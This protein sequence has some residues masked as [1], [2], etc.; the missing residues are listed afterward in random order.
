M[1]K[2]FRSPN[3][4]ELPDD[5]LGE[6]LL[7]LYDRESKDLELFNSI[8]SEVIKLSGSKVNYYKVFIN[9]NFDKVYL[10]ERNKI[11]AKDP[12][13]VWAS[14]DPKPI[15][16]ELSEFGLELSNDQVFVFNKSYIDRILGRPPQAGDVIEAT[17]QNVR[18][19]IYEVQEDSFEVYGVYHYNCFGKVLRDSIDVVDGPVV[20][21]FDQPIVETTLNS[22]LES[23]DPYNDIRPSI[24]STTTNNQEQGAGALESNV[25]LVGETKNIIIAIGQ[26]N[27]DGVS[28]PIQ[29]PTIPSEFLGQQSWYQIW[30]PDDLSSSSGS[31]DSMFPMNAEDPP[32]GGLNATRYSI[33]DTA[34]RFNIYSVRHYDFLL[35]FVKLVYDAQPGTEPVY[36]FKNTKGG[37]AMVSGLEIASVLSWTDSSSPVYN[38][39]GSGLYTTLITDVALGVSSLRARYPNDDI[40]IRAVL[41][42][43]GEFECLDIAGLAGYSGGD[44]PANAWGEAFSGTLYPNLQ[45][46]LTIIETSYGLTRSNDV[47]IPFIIGRTHREIENA[48]YA[49]VDIVRQAQEA[50][51]ADENLNVHLVNLDGLTFKPGENTNL[52]FDAASLTTIGNRFFTKY[53]EVVGIDVQELGP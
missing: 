23:Y 20:D 32:G 52:H 24:S 51:A 38:Y 8:D 2:R 50:V 19:E 16:E 41:M 34:A 3:K 25:T 27:I 53:A 45:R 30:T 49:H 11:I 5:T 12:I 14:Y 42:I 26:S 37:T 28:I 33:G 13:V 10:E 6:S 31:W 36:V 1:K 7:S 46:D 21:T 17:L 9:E 4:I 35:P 48:S 18:Y 44:G 29:D 22:V 39:Q 15:E 43:Q 47:D 40:E